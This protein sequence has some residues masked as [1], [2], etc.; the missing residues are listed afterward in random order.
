MVPSLY[1]SNPG[2][3]IKYTSPTVSGFSM[4]ASHSLD[5]DKADAPKVTDVSVSYG[6]GALATNFAYQEQK[7][8]GVEA[9]KLTAVN[10]SYDLGVAKLLASYGQV[11]AG[12]GKSIDVQFGVDVPVSKA[13]TL[14]AGYAVS[15]DNAAAGDGMRS[16]FGIAA[17]Y[18]LA[19]TTTLYGGY[20]QAET[21][22]CKIEDNVF[23]VGIK[24]AF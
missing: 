4:G 24:H 18:S 20:R 2:N 10:A 13:L 22:D 19:D 15:E 1:Q 14:S 23:A 17:G 12:A 16:G 21:K 8:D 9:I 11:K 5:E 3:T 6:A 7:V